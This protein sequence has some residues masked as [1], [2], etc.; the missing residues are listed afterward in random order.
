MRHMKRGDRG[1]VF[2]IYRAGLFVLGIFS[3]LLIINSYRVYSIAKKAN[4]EH[5]VLQEEIQNRERQ[6]TELKSKITALES[7]EGLELEA[8]GRLNLQKPDEKVLIVVDG[9]DE[10]QKQEA[11]PEDVS[12]LLRL[13][14]WLGFG[15]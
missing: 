12:W 1:A 14:K 4:A 2:Y 7:G 9:S 6:I 5:K 13:K 11:A 15:I 10:K 8:R 3:L